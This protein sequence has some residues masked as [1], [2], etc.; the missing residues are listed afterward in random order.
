MLRQNLQQD[1]IR[2]HH[3]AG[4]GVATVDGSVLLISVFM[5]DVLQ[6]HGRA[7]LY[8]HLLMDYAYLT[9]CKQHAVTLAQTSAT[10]WAMP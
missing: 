10:A 1:H 7:I 3:V 5:R 6:L 4:E 2:G 8:S 9:F